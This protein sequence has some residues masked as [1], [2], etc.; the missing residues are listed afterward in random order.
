MRQLDKNY[1]NIDNDDVYKWHNM[2]VLATF[3]AADFLEV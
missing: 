2:N 1:V 3:C